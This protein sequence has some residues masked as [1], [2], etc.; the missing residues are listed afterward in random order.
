MI[1][2][3]DHNGILIHPALFKH[4]QQFSH[5]V[6][7]IAHRSKVCP[8]RSLDCLLRHVFIPQ[9]ADLQ[10]SLA[11]LI[12]LIL[13]D[14]DLRQGYILAFISVPVFFVDGVRVVR[15]RQRDGQAEGTSG[16]SFTCGGVKV[17]DALV[18]DFLVKV[19]LVGADAGTCL[20]DG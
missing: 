17:A 8:P 5:I 3:E 12:L 7:H 10:Q 16:L 20:Q 14:V 13:R 2:G 4:T 18:H 1:S 9:P 11:V 15:V 6:I 19:Q